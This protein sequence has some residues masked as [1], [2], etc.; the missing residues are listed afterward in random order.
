[1]EAQYA[2]IGESKPGSLPERLRNINQY[3]VTW[4]QKRQRSEGHRRSVNGR[5]W[6]ETRLY[7]LG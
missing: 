6:K 5:E 4:P 1:M 2:E 3:E 7:H